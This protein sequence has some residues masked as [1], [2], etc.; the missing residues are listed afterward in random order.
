MGKETHFPILKY[1]HNI[2][3]LN[4]LYDINFNNYNVM[5]IF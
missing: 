3:Y 1:M 4:N 2:V 5:H